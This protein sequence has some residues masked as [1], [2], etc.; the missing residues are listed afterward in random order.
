MEQT[1]QTV[2]ITKEAQRAMKGMPSRW[3]RTGIVQGETEGGLLVVL[4]NDG[5]TVNVVQ[6]D[7][8]KDKPTKA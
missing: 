2:T 5:S 8:E 4:L 6:Q 3:Y 7:L 1:G